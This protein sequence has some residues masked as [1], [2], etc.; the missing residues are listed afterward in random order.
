MNHGKAWNNHWSEDQAVEAIVAHLRNL[1]GIA[2]VGWISQGFA[3]AF[4]ALIRISLANG[5]VFRLGVAYI[6]D[7]EERAAFDDRFLHD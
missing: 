5:H 2:G 4:Q 3:A 6:Q 7:E 1:D